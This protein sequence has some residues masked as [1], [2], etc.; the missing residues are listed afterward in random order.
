LIYLILSLDYEIFGSGA[1]DVMR[2]IIQPTDRLLNICDK[3]GAKMSIMFEVGEYWAFE[4]YDSRLR[5]DLGYSPCEQMK[6]QAID[7]IQRG[8]DV[9]LHLHPQW[10][11]ARYDKGVWQLCNSYWRLADLPAGLGSKSQIT[12]ITGALHA[13]KETL[14]N[15]IKPVRA[16]YECVCLRAGAFYAQPSRNIISAMKKVGLRAD[17][18]VV[19][20][21][22]ADAPFEVDYSQ[23]IIEK[24]CWW[25]SGTELIME[26]KA[27]ENVL[28]LPVSCRME[29]YWKNFKM[30]KL[31]TTIKRGKIENASSVNQKTDGSIS[32]VPKYHTVLRN[33]IKKH[34][35]TFDFCKLSSNDMLD[36]IREHVKLS[37]QPVVVIGH[38]KDFFNDRGFDRFLA[39]VKH[40]KQVVFQ[41]LSEFIEKKVNNYD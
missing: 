27:G 8:Y 2:D 17:S 16:D 30:T 13:G 25:T 4:R 12:S 11:G 7:A 18:S 20:G 35:N 6:R 5:K 22:K 40:N 28:E 15:M 21:Y 33:L 14:E 19:K 32:S 34:V 39:R 26:G 23:A 10:I 24:R 1:G 29:P 3:H 36:R 31:R 41:S 38:S 37:E 9:Q